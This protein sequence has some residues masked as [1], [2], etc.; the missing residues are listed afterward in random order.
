MVIVMGKMKELKLDE[1]Y[2]GILDHNGKIQV[3]KHD[4][5]QTVTGIYEN[6]IAVK[7]VGKKYLCQIHKDLKDSICFLEA[8]DTAFVKFRK[9]VAWLVGFQKRPTPPEDIV[10]EGDATLLEYFQEQKRLSVRG[11][12]IE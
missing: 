3:A 10:I 11:G 7:G 2:Y 9:G 12:G 5:E 1:N 6:E 8:G 4:K